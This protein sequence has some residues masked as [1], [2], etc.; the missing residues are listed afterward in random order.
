MFPFIQKAGRLVAFAPA[1][2]VADV[3]NRPG[4]FGFHQNSVGIAVGGRFYTF[5]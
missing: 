2:I 5:E 4:W 1:T 3:T